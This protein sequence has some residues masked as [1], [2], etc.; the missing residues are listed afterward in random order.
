MYPA[1]ILN[2]K[3]SS[4]P[5]A[6]FISNTSSVKQEKFLKKKEFF[7]KGACGTGP[8]GLLWHEK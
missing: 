1:E 7:F 3:L 4:M 2:S 5:A 6:K 8:A